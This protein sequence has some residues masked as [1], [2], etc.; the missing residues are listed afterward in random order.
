MPEIIMDTDDDEKPAALA[1][2]SKI[3]SRAKQI[4]EE[5]YRKAYLYVQDLHEVHTDKVQSFTW[6]RN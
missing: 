5:A 1:S 3:K 6:V 4:P 2:E